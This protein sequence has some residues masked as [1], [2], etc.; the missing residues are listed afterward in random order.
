MIMRLAHPQ[1]YSHTCSRAF[2]DAVKEA[3]ATQAGS[4]NILASLVKHLDLEFP[5]DVEMRE[6]ARKYLFQIAKLLLEGHREIWIS[7]TLSHG[8]RICVDG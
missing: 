4:E 2:L 1:P 6:F 7:R 8:L 5:E 3:I